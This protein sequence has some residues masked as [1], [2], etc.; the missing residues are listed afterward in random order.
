MRN[1]E[2]RFINLIRDKGVPDAHRKHYGSYMS[3]DDRPISPGCMACKTGSWLCCFIGTKCNLLCPHCPNDTLNSNPDFSSVSEYGKTDID[4]ILKIL[5][6]PM[7]KGVGISGGEPFLYADKLVEWITKI[8]KEYPNLYV[9]NYTNGI[10]ATEDNLKRV[11][12]A[13]VDEVRFDLAAEN[14]SERCLKHMEIATRLIPS[15]GIEVP[16][17]LEQYTDL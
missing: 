7:Y 15:V 6:N 14:Y 8:K 11:A 16:V 12:D 1:F 10:L 2:Y 9:W 17:I 3:F 13:G 5:E 4:G